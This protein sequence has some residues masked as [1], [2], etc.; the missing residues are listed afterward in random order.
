MILLPQPSALHMALAHLRQKG[1]YVRMQF[2]DYSSAFNTIVPSSL[3]TPGPC[4]QQL[5]VY[6]DQRLS[7]QL[8]TSSPNCQPSPLLK[9][10]SQQQ[11]D[12]PRALLPLHMWL[13]CHT[14]LNHVFA[15]DTTAAGLIA[16]INETACRDEVCSVTRWCTDNN[17]TLNIKKTQEIILDF[18]KNK[19]QHSPLTINGEEAGR[20]SF[21][22]FSGTHISENLT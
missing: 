2:I 20:V 8:S 19:R 15:D 4:S 11:C 6:V 1:T 5:S 14:T 18:R 13:H 21:F 22:K 9:S 12:E 10:I 3:Q 17:F 16:N 7:I